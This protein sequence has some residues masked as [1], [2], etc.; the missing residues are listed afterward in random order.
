MPDNQTRIRPLEPRDRE[1]IRN[2]CRVTAYRNAGYQVAFEDGEIF[3]DY[4]TSWYTDFDREHSLVLEQNGIVTA[5]LL[6]CIHTRTFMK[7]MALRIMPK[8]I[9]RILWRLATGR[10]RNPATKRMLRWSLLNAA[11]EA[12]A[13]PFDVYPAHYHCNILPE[14]RGTHAYTRLVNA[15]LDHLEARNVPGVFGQIDE[16]AETGP[17]L[18]MVTRA[19]RMQSAQ[20]YAESRSTMARDVFLQPTPEM[21]NRVWAD[22]PQNYRLFIETASRYFRI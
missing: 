10:Y 1:A 8:L 5:Y 3:A 12:P 18:R 16:P 2:I 4:W 17:W 14:A 13:V 19:E 15:F 6:G 7:D 9:M 22:T 20:F 21:R 11:R